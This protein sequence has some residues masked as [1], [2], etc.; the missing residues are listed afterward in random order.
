MAKPVW[1][2]TIEDQ[3]VQFLWM[4]KRKSAGI[5]CLVFQKASDKV[6]YCKLLNQNSHG[7][8]CKFYVKRPGKRE[9]NDNF[10][11]EKGF[12]EYIYIY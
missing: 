12:V 4:K 10:N 1:F 11:Q 7:T 3:S 6:S 5:I 9:A 8:R 2:L